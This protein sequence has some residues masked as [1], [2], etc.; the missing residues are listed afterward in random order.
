MPHSNKNYVVTRGLFTA[1]TH[2]CEN[3]DIQEIRDAQKVC[4]GD[5]NC[6]MKA[7]ES[8]DKKNGKSCSC[9]SDY[10][11]CIGGGGSIPVPIPGQLKKIFD[12]CKGKS[13]N[14][15]YDCQSIVA[16]CCQKNG[17]DCF[18]M[19]NDYCTDNGGHGGGG[20]HPSKGPKVGDK[21]CRFDSG[22]C[23]YIGTCYENECNIDGDTCYA[24]DSD[25]SK[26]EAAQGGSGPSPGSNQGG[27]DPESG[28]NQ[29]AWTSDERAQFI[30]DLRKIKD[31]HTHEAMPLN[32]AQCI[33][34]NTENKYSY[35]D[36]IAMKDDEKSEK[37]F[38]DLTT[39]CTKNPGGSGDKLST[40]AIVGIVVG[41]LIFAIA[42]IALIRNLM[43]K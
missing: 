13:D 10:G 19:A 36:F 24:N 25:C 28:H 8:V 1:G 7:C 22:G 38:K 17:V 4:D 29:N 39:K 11:D 16:D 35:A 27:L 33:E 30:K 40:G 23:E 42:A 14:T 31:P 5:K 21:C 15:H 34:K 37:F 32:V 41:S 3:S 26:C 20:D 12:Q 9:T 18:A 2:Q 43:K 6:C